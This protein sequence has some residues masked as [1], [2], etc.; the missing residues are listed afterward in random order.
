MISLDEPAQ[1]NPAQAPTP[2]VAP[3]TTGDLRSRL[4][5]ALVEAKQVHIADAIEHSEISESPNDLLITTSKMYTMYLKQPGFEAAV[6]KVLGKIT[7]ITIKVGEVA[8]PASSPAQS[9]KPQT[10]EAAQRAL[11]NPEV[12]R[13]QELFPDSQVRTVRNLSDN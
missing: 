13:F 1:S 2:S 3:V 12:Q 8:A 11:A 10:D 9:A 5:A 4:H 6:L 7:R